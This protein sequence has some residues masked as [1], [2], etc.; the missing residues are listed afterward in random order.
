MKEEEQFI[1]PTTRKPIIT[2]AL[3]QISWSD[4]KEPGAYVEVASGNLYRIPYEALMKGASPVIMMESLGFSKYVK[5][6]DNPFVALYTARVLC[7]DQ[8]IEPNF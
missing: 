7:I 5:L 8:N 6:S 2:T 3:P 1:R 4:I